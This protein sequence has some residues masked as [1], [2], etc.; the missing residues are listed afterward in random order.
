MAQTLEQLRTALA[1][2][3]ERLF[4]GTATAAGTTTTLIDTY[5]LDR[6]TETDALAGALLYISD[7]TDDLAPKGQSQFIKAYNASSNTIT[8]YVPFTA[9]PGTG[10]TYEIYLAPLTLEQWNQCVNDAS[11]NAWPE[12]WRPAKEEIT[13]TGSPTYSLSGLTDRVLGAEITF[14]SA[15]LGYPAQPLLGWYTDGDPGD[16][17]LHLSRP[18]PSSSNMTIKLLTAQR[19][20]Y[21]LVPG[22]STELDPTYILMAGRVEFYRRM[23]DASRQSDRGGFLQLMAHWQEKAEQRKAALA[24]AVVGFQQ[25]ARKEKK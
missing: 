16:L 10:D 1:K 22:E 15:L 9:A 21:D 5:G 8:V 12:V 18:V 6:F 17:T 4:A 2:S 13:P 7:T 19:Y 3:V 24:A 20:Y 11:G 25:P 14:K 23:A